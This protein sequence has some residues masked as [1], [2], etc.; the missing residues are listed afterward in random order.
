MSRARSLICSLP[1]RPAK[2]KLA[3]LVTVLPVERSLGLGPLGPAM[4][5]TELRSFCS[6]SLRG[7]TRGSGIHS[8]TNSSVSWKDSQLGT[9][10]VAYT[11]NY[12]TFS[13]N[14]IKCLPDLSARVLDCR[15]VRM[16]KMMRIN[17][18]IVLPGSFWWEDLTYRATTAEP[19]SL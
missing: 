11:Y 6:H 13:E 3:R 12:T 2:L 19:G 8:S 4:T 7:C 1:A 16:A 5:G 14:L 18:R 15:S 10:T 17:S 9:K